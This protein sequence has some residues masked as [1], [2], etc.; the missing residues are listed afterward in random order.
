[1]GMAIVAHAIKLKISLPLL[2]SSWKTSNFNFGLIQIKLVIPEIPIAR[3][4]FHTSCFRCTMSNW[5]VMSHL[6]SI[7]PM[8]V[9]KVTIK[10]VGN[11]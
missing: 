6:K 2:L 1:M 9:D 4:I 7:I 10:N 5:I 8:I 11:M 3:K